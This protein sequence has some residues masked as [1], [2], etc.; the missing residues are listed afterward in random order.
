[1]PTIS[2]AL[3]LGLAHHQARRWQ[4]AESIYRQVLAQ[5]P[6]HAET[7]NCYAALVVDAGRR[8]EAIALLEQAVAQAPDNPRFVTNLGSVYHMAGRHEQALETLE[9]SLQLDP[10][11][12]DTFYHLGL[13][14]EQAARFDE[15]RA[16]YHRVLQLEPRHR[17][18]H[19][20]LGVLLKYQ[21]QFDAAL[22]HFNEALAIDPTSRHARYNRGAVL[23]TLGKFVEGFRD[24]ES[25]LD[26]PE[27][28]IRR[29]PE[30][31]WD[32]TPL[33]DSSLVI[34]GEQ[35][36]GDMIQFVRYLPM[37]RARCQHVTLELPPLVLPLFR[38]S[39]IEN[40]TVQAPT[41]EPLPA[42]GATPYDF[43]VP[44]L[45]LPRVFGTTVS[46]IPGGVPYL[47]AGEKREAQWQARMSVIPGLKV[48]IVWQGRP[49]HRDD[50]YRSIPLAHFAPLSEVR[51]VSLLSL[52]KGHGSDQL[53][54]FQQR[55]AAVDMQQFIDPRQDSLLEVAAIIKNLDL[56]ITCD[57]SLGHLAGA[58]G[59]PVWVA[60]PAF[61]D[62][63]WLRDRADTLWYPTMRLFRQQQQG[64]WEPVFAEMAVELNG[65]AERRASTIES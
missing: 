16:Y 36:I 26:F 32:G 63:R 29:R 18:A 31:L 43:Q 45:S 53:P 42:A 20:N 38:E 55:F 56:L 33:G 21:C 12:P 34:H 11:Q 15:A 61:A 62:W 17:S 30:P 47:H 24:Y 22:A 2:E 14:M 40:L 58:L 51:G 7:L 52:Q 46:T 48:G 37:V 35:G 25:R 60:L 23:L 1:M 39:G 54:V 64:V 49:T 9:R 28:G 8:D 3:A 10:Q 13:V 19:V 44:L 27:F 4:Q 65:L 6:G 57:T 59:T 50:R 41:N 5:C